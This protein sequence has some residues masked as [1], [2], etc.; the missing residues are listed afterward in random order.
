[1]MRVAVLC[2]FSGI[3]RDAFTAAGHSAFS[4]DLLPSE[5]PGEHIRD[6][7]RNVPLDGVDLIIAHPPCTYLANSGVRWLHER[8]ERWPLLFDAAELFRWVLD[9]PVPRIAVE[10]PVMHRY[11][12]TLIG[13]RQAQSIQPWQFGHGEVKRTCL[14]LKGLP[15]LEPT[16]IV[17]GRAGVVW[18]M[19]PSET[20]S[21]DRSRTYTGIAEAMATQW[22]ATQ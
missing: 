18:R 16:N 5:R 20:R 3:V 15:L 10:N 19:A 2:E 4:V 22:G 7:I 12:R 6:D 9:L 17:D 14:W 8:V 13:Q 21:Q 1:M 11:A